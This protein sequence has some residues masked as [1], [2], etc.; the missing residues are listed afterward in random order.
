MFSRDT[1]ASILYTQ[2]A[3]ALGD[4]DLDGYYVFLAIAQSIVHEIA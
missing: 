1:F 2:A 4:I 3:T